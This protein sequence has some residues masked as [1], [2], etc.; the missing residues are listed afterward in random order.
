MPSS[1]IRYIH[2]DEEHRELRVGFVD[3]D[4]YAY[5]G[6]EPRTYADFRAARSKGRFFAARVRD[7]Y[8]YRRVRRR[9]P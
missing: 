7:H 2:Y 6:V 5:D 1:A 3:G 8:P 4:D 9:E